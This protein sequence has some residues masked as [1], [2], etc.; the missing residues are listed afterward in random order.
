MRVVPLAIGFLLLAGCG[1][2][3]AA[4]PQDVLDFVKRRA[5]CLHWTGEEGYDAAR[6]AEINAAYAKLNCAALAADETALKAR[7]S[8]NASVQQ[9]LG[10]KPD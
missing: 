6:R 3:S 4:P 10:R 8:G 2:K 9:L 5:D 7:Y 1:Q